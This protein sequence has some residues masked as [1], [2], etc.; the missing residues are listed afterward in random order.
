MADQLATLTDLASLLQSDV[1]NST[2]TMLLELATSIVQ[3]AAGG[4][5]IIDLTD[6]AVVDASWDY[7]L[8]L[9]QRPVRSVTL[10]K[11]D[12]TTVTDA[13][14]RGQSLWRAIGWME[15]SSPPSTVAVTY[16]HGYPAGSQYLQLARSMVLSLAQAGYGN[17]SSV[18][19]ESIDDY[20]VS[21][22]QAA[23]RMQL[24]PF[25]ADAIADAYGFSTYVTESRT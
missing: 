22:D 12:G 11:I 19:S 4:Q 21:Y 24:T 13:F 18:S 6:T 23:A 25:M 16:V 17:P 15:S 3:Q 7:W 1:D 14:L 9:P 8:D 10:V 5:R 20:S 2:G